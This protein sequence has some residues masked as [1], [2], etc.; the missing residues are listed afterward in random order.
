MD[1]TALLL[2]DGRFPAGGHAHSGGV[3]ATVAS[4]GVTDVASLEQFL[5][6]RVSASGAVNAAFAAAA[7]R[8]F[9]DDSWTSLQVLDDELDARIPSPVLRGASRSLGRQLLRTARR[10]W[11][12]SAIDVDTVGR[13]GLH[14]PVALG[15][16]AV[17]A[18]LTP[19]RAATLA[20][21]DAV[22]A[23]ATAAVR[24]LGLDPYAVHRTLAA[25]TPLVER[26]AADGAEHADTPP[27]A[28]P[29]W[30]TPVLDI[31]VERHATA[32]VRLFA[33]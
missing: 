30:G 4:G 32:E 28:L 27:H 17:S 3:E 9:V 8:A 5:R 21:Y 7:C 12:G 16:V 13:H 26:V 19:T 24:L 11:P 29:A 14:Q 10:V 23:P 22:S 25:L 2:A 31:A 18:G 6:G 15:A 33:S 1:V 20:A